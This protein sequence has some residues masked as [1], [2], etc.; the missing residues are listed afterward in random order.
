MS[1]FETIN[2]TR[3]AR[4]FNQ[5]DAM[6]VVIRARNL[7]VVDVND[8]FVRHTG[9]ARA[10]IVGLAPG[11]MGLWL[12][13]QQ[14]KS[15]RQQITDAGFVSNLPV[16]FNAANGKFGD[17]ILTVEPFQFSGMQFFLGLT[18]DIR[19]FDSP[20]VALERP[21][22]DF[23]SF[24][25]DAD[26]G[27]YRIWTNRTVE[28]NVSLA[29]IMG[30]ESVRELTKTFIESQYKLD[31]YVDPNEMQN[32]L[33]MLQNTGKIP[34]RRVE[35]KKLNGR[36]FWALESA[37]AI[38]D[39]AGK[40]ICIEGRIT[41]IS[42]IDELRAA[43]RRLEAKYRNVIE[44]TTEGI[45]IT[46]SQIVMFANPAVLELLGYSADEFIGMNYVDK[47]CAPEDRA[48]IH[49]RI[50]RRGSGESLAFDYE[51]RAIRRDGKMRLVKVHTFSIE[52]E[53][54]PAVM[55][56]MRDITDDR[57][58]SNKLMRAQQ[59]YQK[60]FDNAT[61]GMFQVASDGTL[62]EANSA[63]VRMFG[64]DSTEQFRMHIGNLLPAFADEDLRELVGGA[65][66]QGKELETLEARMIHRKGHE[67]W[68]SLSLRASED[69]DDP[70]RLVIDGSM[71]DVSA[72]RL[73]ELQ[74]SFQ[75][76]HDS[77]TRMPNRARFESILREFIDRLHRGIV[78]LEK[79]HSYWVLLLDLDGFKVVNDSLGHAAGDEL[80]VMICDRLAKELLGELMISRYGGDEFAIITRIAH[81]LRFA[82]HMAERCLDIL[83]EPFLV[84][85]QQ[86][87]ASA[88]IGIAA[89]NETCKDS[90]Q[91]MRDVDTAMYRAKAAGKSRYQVFDN[92]MHRAAQDRLQIETDL[93][94]AF[95]RRELITHYQPIVDLRSSAIVGAEA[96]VRWR[97]P[98]RGL[99]FPNAFLEVAEESGALVA[100]DW[101]VI[102][103][104]CRQMLL[105]ERMYKDVAP[106][107]MSVNISDRL[108]ATRDF[109]GS[110]ADL[111]RVIGIDA[112]K[113]HLE[114]TETVFRADSAQMLSVLKD[115]KAIGVML[116]VDDFGTG[117]SSLASFAHASFDGLKIDRSFVE[118]IETN[119]RN[120]ALVKTICQF[121]KDLNLSLVC[122]GV[123]RDTQA[124]WISAFGCDVGQG[125]R[126][127]PAIPAEAFSSRLALALA[128]H[129]DAAQQTYVDSSL[130]AEHLS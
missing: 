54:G 124:E 99:L 5:S 128:A 85:G 52:L 69:L 20:E 101:F 45:F 84:R 87:F 62:L 119:D 36:S 106:K 125:F 51:L 13:D 122:E 91:V 92:T 109:A 126:Y 93:R 7:T 68:V 33:D 56:T 44:N 11:A 24:F 108:F 130:D 71:Q 64:F 120:R 60:L 65:F 59:R 49:E 73:A 30:Y 95:E 67:F 15:V 82:I 79:D 53:D 98:M 105:W 94:F 118:D 107:S 1:E 40:M 12:N 74:L 41:D 117:Y 2:P 14:R 110:L 39:Q 113:L 22:A 58:F 6:V 23:S 127:A 32:A 16:S 28:A 50:K 18:Q 37:R 27:L 78:K 70:G 29:Q 83:S 61:V 75:A 8:T 97:H 48:M 35:L 21:L 9:I 86:V 96:L 3:L 102:D 66:E 72:R 4:C 115:L 42:A 114:I 63:L 121:A 26:Q 88:S 89:L 17:G 31:H 90:N 112:R 25:R 76:N 57:E 100:I 19:I 77:L 34:E 43:S 81:E 38:S 104:A 46:R 116:V 111:I 123:E 10:D 129:K 55:G 103:Q 47:I 80:L